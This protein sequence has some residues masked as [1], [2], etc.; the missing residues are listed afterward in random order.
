[1]KTKIMPILF[2]L[3]ASCYPIKHEENRTNINDNII[4][5]FTLPPKWTPTMT[6]SRLPSNTSIITL[7]EEEI[8]PTFT[9]NIEFPPG[10]FNC[11]L[12]EYHMGWAVAVLDLFPDGV[13]KYSRGSNFTLRTWSYSSDTKELYVSQLGT[14][15]IFS[16]DIIFDENNDEQETGI[17]C[18]RVK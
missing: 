4:N 7:T 15:E 16:P 14:F 12:M 5:S 10:K 17:D 6:T 11:T 8:S 18:E 2:I 3:L 1:M 13:S 9:Y